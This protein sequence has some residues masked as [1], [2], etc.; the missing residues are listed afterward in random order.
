MINMISIIPR[1]GLLKYDLIMRFAATLLSYS[2]L[3]FVTLSH[4][5]AQ[6][7][8]VGTEILSGK[9]VE[10]VPGEKGSVVVFLSARCPCSNSHIELLK[11]WAEEFKDFSFV[12]VHSNADE[13]LKMSQSYFKNAGLPFAVID[14]RQG[15]LADR[16]KALK[17]PHAFIMD[18]AGSIRYRGGITNSNHGET[19]KRQFLREAL[20]DI[21]T[22]QKVKTA[23]TRTLGCLISR[24][25]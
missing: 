19:A 3:I 16:F 5:N 13:D 8:V 1:N 21:N 12:A 17:T 9:S 15:R 14:D 24:G 25:D 4:G 10:I 11:N 6:A 2:V 22:G 7:G 18:A 23:E 20:S